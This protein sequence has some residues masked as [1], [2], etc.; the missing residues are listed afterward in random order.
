[1]IN[2]LLRPQAATAVFFWQKCFESEGRDDKA[3]GEKVFLKSLKMKAGMS[4]D[5]F[6][7]TFEAYRFETEY[8]EEN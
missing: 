5:Y 3:K 2:P 8:I 7:P 4:P 6:S 1:M